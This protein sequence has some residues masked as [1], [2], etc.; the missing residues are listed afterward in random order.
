MTIEEQ[1]K[2]LDFGVALYT[3]STDVEGAIYA[4]ELIYQI[5]KKKEIK[6]QMY[7]GSYSCKYEDIV[8]FAK[9]NNL[10]L[11]DYTYI[12]EVLSYGRLKIKL[13]KYSRYITLNPKYKEDAD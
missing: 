12:M 6:E 1:Q 9:I 13:T 5:L 11:R 10:Q 3:N 4:V 8:K 7:S 2:Q